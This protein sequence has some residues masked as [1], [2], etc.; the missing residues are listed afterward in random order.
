MTGAWLIVEWVAWV[1]LVYYLIF[2]R[3]RWAELLR[4]PKRSGLL[5][6]VAVFLYG[7]TWFVESAVLLRVCWVVAPI[8]LVTGMVI[9]RKGLI[10]MDRERAAGLEGDIQTLRLS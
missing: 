4:S 10:Q 1:P 5:S 2:M 3:R 9:Q 6:L 7:A 8:M